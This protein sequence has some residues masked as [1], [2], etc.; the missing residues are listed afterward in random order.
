MNVEKLNGLKLEKLP[1]YEV[2]ESLNEDETAKVNEE[3][4][5]RKEKKKRD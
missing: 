1:S 5:L 3:V 2:T 4:N